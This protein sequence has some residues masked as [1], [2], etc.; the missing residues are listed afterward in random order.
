ML[1]T[2][3]ELPFDSFFLS[4]ARLLTF[5]FMFRM[6]STNKNETLVFVTRYVIEAAVIHLWHSLVRI[7]KIQAISK[8]SLYIIIYFY[9]QSRSSQKKCFSLSVSKTNRPYPQYDTQNV[10]KCMHCNWYIEHDTCTFFKCW[11]W[12]SITPRLENYQAII[13]FLPLML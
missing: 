5:K 11:S 8:L 6:Q 1:I 10:A 13:F 3:A 12:N 7:I 2:L 9:W 4:W